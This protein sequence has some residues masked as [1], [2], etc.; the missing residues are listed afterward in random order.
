MQKRGIAVQRRVNSKDLAHTEWALIST[1]IY[2]LLEKFCMCPQYGYSLPH[3]PIWRSF[4]GAQR[5][6]LP[7]MKRIIKYMQTIMPEDDGPPYAIMPS[8]ITAFQS[9]PVRI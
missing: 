3:S 7:Q 6:Q 8:Y 1:V 4:Q 2:S 5:I 9:S